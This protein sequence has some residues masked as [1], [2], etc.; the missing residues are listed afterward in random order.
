MLQLSDHRFWLIYMIQNLLSTI[1]HIM[2]QQKIII[3]FD[4]FVC[5][6]VLSCPKWNVTNNFERI[7]TRNRLQTKFK[8]GFMMKST[9]IDMIGSLIF[10]SSLNQT[11]DLIHDDRL[12]DMT[13]C[14]HSF[15]ALK[16]NRLSKLKKYYTYQCYCWFNEWKFP[17]WA[18]SH[19]LIINGSDK[20]SINRSQ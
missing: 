3:I 6:L 15:L 14:F 19:L 8:L 12:S 10:L 11:F 4:L 9:S 13:C 1:N 18:L 2:V 7:L 5:L 20:P 17:H 16:S